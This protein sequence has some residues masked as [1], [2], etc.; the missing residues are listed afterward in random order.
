MH[1][2]LEFGD[3]VAQLKRMTGERNADLAVVV[4]VNTSA[5]SARMTGKTEWKLADVERL[6]EHWGVEISDLVMGPTHAAQAYDQ[7]RPE[8]MRYPK[9]TGQDASPYAA[10]QGLSTR[11]A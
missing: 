8:S 7:R 10:D 11:A 5:F 1:S 3:T 4:G 6:A 2:Q 9:S